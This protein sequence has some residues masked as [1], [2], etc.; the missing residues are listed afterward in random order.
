MRGRV[1]V[2]QLFLPTHSMT[3][4][5]GLHHPWP[6]GPLVSHVPYAHRGDRRH[7]QHCAGSPDPDCLSHA[8]GA[9]STGPADLD[10]SSCAVSSAGVTLEPESQQ[11]QQGEPLHRR[12]ASHGKNRVSVPTWVS[13]E[14][15]GYAEGCGA[16]KPMSSSL[17]GL[18]DLI[19]QNS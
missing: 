13:R 1:R 14:G 7:A 4:E 15:W 18:R 2:T 5:G 10:R 17:S 6:I 16:L 11:H 8:A 3:P 9:S 12:S 19:S